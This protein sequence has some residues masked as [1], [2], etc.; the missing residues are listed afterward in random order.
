MALKT[1]LVELLDCD[2]HARPRLGSSERVLI[3]PTFENGAK[4]TSSKHTI[5]AEVSGG[6]LEIRKVEALE[7]R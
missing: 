3:D 7:V 1:F 2:D 6:H 4:S 5:W